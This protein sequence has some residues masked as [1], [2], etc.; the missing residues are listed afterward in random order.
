[1]EKRIFFVIFVEIVIN[2]CP[3]ITAIA[4]YL[5]YGFRFY[6]ERSAVPR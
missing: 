5:S 2:I 3:Y 1:M 4:E 6:E